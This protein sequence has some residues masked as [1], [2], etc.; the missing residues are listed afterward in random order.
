MT[1]RQRVH[2][3]S[4]V[5]RCDDELGRD[6]DRRRDLLHDRRGRHRRR[7]PNQLRRVLQH[8]DLHKIKL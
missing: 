7:R 3:P 2:Q 8:D 5:G 4:G 1:G 6:L